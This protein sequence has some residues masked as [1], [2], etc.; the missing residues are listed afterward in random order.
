LEVFFILTSVFTT[1]GMESLFE[2][3]KLGKWG[4]TILGLKLL[5]ITALLIGSSAWGF[6]A[7]LIERTFKVQIFRRG[8]RD[9]YHIRPNLLKLLARRK[10]SAKNIE[11]FQE[12]K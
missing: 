8:Y 5:G 4:I 11:E 10:K 1:D 3:Y 7:V 2:Y 6:L 12:N 9:S